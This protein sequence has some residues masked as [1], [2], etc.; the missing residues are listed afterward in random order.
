M[1]DTP[2]SEAIVPQLQDI[3]LWDIQHLPGPLS[4]SLAD[5]KFS[6]SIQLPDLLSVESGS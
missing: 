4:A 1:V 5:P 2:M 3:Q 6:M